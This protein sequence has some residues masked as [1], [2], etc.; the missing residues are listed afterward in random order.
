MPLSTR[1]FPK[2]RSRKKKEVNPE[3]RQYLQSKHW[4]ETKALILEIA[5]GHCQKCH[6][7]SDRLVVHHKHY[8]TLWHETPKDLLALCSKC[9]LKAHRRKWW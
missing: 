9:N 3:Y 6:E 2:R 4:Q 1:W 8:K 7:S 5:D